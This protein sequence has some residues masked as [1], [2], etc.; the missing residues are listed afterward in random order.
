MKDFL[1]KMCIGL[2]I[3]IVCVILVINAEKCPQ[4]NSIVLECIQIDEG[5]YGYHVYSHGEKVFQF[6]EDDLIMLKKE[7]Y[8]MD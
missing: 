6:T 1:Q 4:D 7:C 5:V 2:G 3:F 8:E